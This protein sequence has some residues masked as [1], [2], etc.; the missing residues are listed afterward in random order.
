MTTWLFA[1]QDD[2][3]DGIPDVLEGETVDDN[4]DFST[5]TLLLIA[6]I[7]AAL[8]LFVLR[9]RKGGGGDLGEVNLRHL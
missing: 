3:N 7:G 6:L 8:V 5:G 4:D 9:I 2:D 1:D